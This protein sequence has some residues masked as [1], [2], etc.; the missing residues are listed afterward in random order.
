MKEL[1]LLLLLLVVTT[2]V[3]V[4]VRLL[5]KTLP[6]HGTDIRPLTSV[7]AFVLHQMVFSLKTFSTE[8]TCK[9]STVV[10]KGARYRRLLT[11][12]G[13]VAGA[14]GHVKAG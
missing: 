3:C 9:G 14:A 7:R 1:R 2:V 13:G 10:E 11:T 8:P 4:Q 6:T 12:T 5:G